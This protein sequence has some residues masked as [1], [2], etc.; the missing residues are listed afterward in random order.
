MF[1]GSYRL[2]AMPRPPPH[3]PLAPAMT[4]PQIPSGAGRSVGIK[5][6]KDGN[7]D[8]SCSSYDN[9]SAP[10]GS[11]HEETWKLAKKYPFFSGHVHLDWLG[12]P[13]RADTL[14]V[15]CDQFLFWNH[16]SRRV[17][18]R[19]SYLHANKASGPTN[20]VL[21]LLPH[22]NWK[23]GDNVDV[24]AYFNN[25]DEVELFLNGKSLGTRRKQADD[26]HVQWRVPF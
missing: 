21:H 10:W 22:W 11:T 19:R 16:R 8:Y 17:S 12:L 15:A 7:K 13:R 18:E 3:W 24:W 4:C 23:A 25:A 6:L 20:P 1:P 5:P 2:S 9:C 26:L 14:S